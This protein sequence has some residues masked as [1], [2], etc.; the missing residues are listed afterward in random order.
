MF[1]RIANNQYFR[2]ALRTGRVVSLTYV[3]YMCGQQDGISMYARNPKGVE[4]DL[5][6]T[7]LGESGDSKE[8]IVHHWTTA[9]YQRVDSITRMILTVAKKHCQEKIKEYS[10][11]KSV[12]E[13]NFWRD[14]LWLLNQNWECVVS[15]KSEVNAFVT[16]LLPCKVFVHG[17]ILSVL[18]A[19][20]DE[21]AIILAHEISHVLLGHVDKASTHSALIHGVQ[22]VLL[23]LVDPIGIFSLCFEFAVDLLR[24]LVMASYSRQHEIEADTLGVKL[25]AGA[26]FNVNEG[27]LVF[28]KLQKLSKSKEVSTSNSSMARFW[29]DSHPASSDRLQS[30]QLLASQHMK[31]TALMARCGRMRGDLSAVGL[32]RH[33]MGL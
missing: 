17:G 33:Y 16:A 29:L 14:K 23:S 1:H 19:S 13:S 30:L 6:F 8:S 24:R 26:C 12:D 21:L 32:L 20:D 31:D 22:L 11:L 9:E 2:R 15:T 18:D 10:T 28:D 4:R 5:L 27:V 3:V 25:A 7:L